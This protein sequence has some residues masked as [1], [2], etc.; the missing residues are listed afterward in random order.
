[1]TFRHGKKLGDWHDGGRLSYGL[2]SSIV[3]KINL[4]AAVLSPPVLGSG[5]SLL[6][7]GVLSKAKG[8]EADCGMNVVAHAEI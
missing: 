3:Q 1:M 4:M 8:T 2:R 5:I 6:Y 7:M